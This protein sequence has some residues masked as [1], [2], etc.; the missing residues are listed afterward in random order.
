MTPSSFLLVIILIKL[1]VEQ[2]HAYQLN[3]Q[4]DGA[5]KHDQQVVSIF[6]VNFNFVL[7]FSWHFLYY[8]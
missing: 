4:I 2:L 3:G 8:F 5:K 1:K 6:G 7:F